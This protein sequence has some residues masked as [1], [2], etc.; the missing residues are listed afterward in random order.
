MNETLYE[1]ELD[2]QFMNANPI[3]DVR[4]LFHVNV[5]EREVLNFINR[6]N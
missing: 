5:V 1:T 4:L 3:G 6:R 2:A